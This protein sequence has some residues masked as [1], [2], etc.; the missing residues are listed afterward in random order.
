MKQNQT[1]CFYI[2]NTFFLLAKGHHEPWHAET[3]G[4][5]SNLSRQMLFNCSPHGQLFSVV[6]G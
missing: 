5:L 1:N 6:K 4:M 2:C 3:H